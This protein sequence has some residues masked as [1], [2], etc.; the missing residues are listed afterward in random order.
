M[1][2]NE[3]IQLGDEGTKQS[4]RRGLVIKNLIIA[5][6]FFAMRDCVFLCFSSSRQAASSPLYIFIC[7]GEPALVISWFLAFSHTNDR[8]LSRSFGLQ[9]EIK[10]EK[11]VGF[12]YAYEPY[13]GLKSSG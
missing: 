8:L 11:D 9:R 1:L 12:S 6:L 4:K 10:G 5:Q 7:D 13:D 3:L 2:K